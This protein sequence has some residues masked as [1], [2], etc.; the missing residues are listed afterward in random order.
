MLLSIVTLNYKKP[1]LTIDCLRSVYT[2]FEKEFESGEIEL[3]I[4]D[5]A[6][7]DESVQLLKKEISKHKHVELIT[8]PQNVGFSKGCNVGA[9]SAKGK[10]ILFL[11]NDTLVRDRGISAM[12][13]Y[14]QEHQEIAI[15]GGQMSNDDGTPQPSTGEFYTPLNAFLFLLGM[16][17]L[18]ISDKS[19]TKIME[20]DWVKGGLFMIQSDVFRNLG[21][22]DEQIFMYTEDMELCYRAKLAGYKTYFYPDISIIHKEQGSSNR[23][24]AIVYI[25]K[26]LLYFY[27]KHR[28][29][30]EYLFIKSLLL[31]KAILL[32]NIGKITGNKYLV[33]TYKEAIRV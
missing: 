21:G 19:P 28:T 15:L 16:Q 27:K 22:F 12:A 24:F 9:A 10:F 32:I 2:Q 25:Y 26:N 20:V 29:Y 17:K 4:V 14:M 1:Q 5:N 30:Q 13:H 31:A 11:N 6:S 3:I 33:T 23:T 18:G 8:N 7:G